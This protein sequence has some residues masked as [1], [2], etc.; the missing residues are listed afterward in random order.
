MKKPYPASWRFLFLDINFRG[1]SFNSLVGW[2]R[3]YHIHNSSHRNF[4]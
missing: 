4:K 2:K 3:P 1:I